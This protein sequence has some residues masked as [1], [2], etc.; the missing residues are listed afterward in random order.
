MKEDK[1]LQLLTDY[2][3]GNLSNEEIQAVENELNTNASARK[4][5][6][7]L[8]EV[9]GTIEDSQELEPSQKLQQN[10]DALLVAEMEKKKVGGK[11]VFFQ[12]LY[13]KAAAV[14]LMLIVAGG[15]GYFISEEQNNHR[16]AEKI[17]AAQSVML[18]KLE[19]QH[20]VSQRLIGIHEVYEGTPDNELVKA[21]I[22]LMN[23]DTNTNVRLAAVNALVKFYDEPHVRQALINALSTQTDP[24]VQIELIQILVYK[25]EQEAVKPLENIIK[26][27]QTLQAVK[28]EAYAGLFSLS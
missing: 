6:E 1:L 26:D 4:I 3:D 17:E 12:S 19:N 21:L 7:Q 9:L 5:F 24:L 2:F 16:L 11:I 20:S 14:V 8:N 23:E 15:V 18:A 13:F 10:F 28:D 22:K 25:E 27:D